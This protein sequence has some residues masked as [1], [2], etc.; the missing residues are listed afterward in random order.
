MLIDKQYALFCSTVLLK[1]PLNGVMFCARGQDPSDGV[2][3]GYG[4]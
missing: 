2:K 3:E 1:K 4:F